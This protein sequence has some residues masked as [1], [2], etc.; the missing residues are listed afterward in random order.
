MTLMEERKFTIVPYYSQDYDS[1]LNFFTMDLQ[2]DAIKSDSSLSVDGMNLD[3]GV[4][5]I[6]VTEKIDEMGSDGY[7][8][9]MYS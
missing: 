1:M 5:N 9:S 2:V 3:H 8:G 6:N 7:G 4:D